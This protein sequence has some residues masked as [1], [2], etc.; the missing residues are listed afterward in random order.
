MRLARTQLG[1]SLVV[2][3][4][5]VV[6]SVQAQAPDQ[7]T[8]SALEH[9]HP[10]FHVPSSNMK[11][12]TAAARFR[13]GVTGI[14]SLVNFSGSYS[15]FGY[16]TV[17]N[18]Q[19]KWFYNMVGKSPDQGG[20]TVI[21]APIVPVSVLLLDANGAP[22]YSGGHLLYSDAT[23][24]VQKLVQSPIFENFQYSSSNTPTQ[25]SDAVQRAEFWRVI[26]RDSKD[27]DP[28]N[29]WHTLLKP[30]VK[31]PRLMLL[32]FG[33]YQFALN[34]DG[35]CCSFLLVDERTFTRNLF[36]ATYPVDGTTAVGAAELA[37]DV[38]TADMS[39]FLFPN[40]Y[41]YLN[42][43]VSDCC[44]LGFHSYDVEPG[45]PEN[46][47]L[48]RRY[49]LNYSSWISPG[50]FGGGFEDITAASH[51]IAEIY[52]DPFV[53]SD[54][55]LNVTPWWRAPDGTTCMNI[56]ET[57]DV[58]EGLP[59][60]TYPINLNGFTYHPQNEAL[61][62]WFEFRAPSNAIDQAYSYPDTSVLT[63]L[64]DVYK[65]GCK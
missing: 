7:V 28:G 33:S 24:Y 62:Q 44:V 20:T 52:N 43:N 51:E 21:N 16:D 57:G 54:G 49:V 38:T 37:G 3:L 17:G 8:A 15:T 27:G 47:N 45:V 60:A 61:L 19:S 23:Q 9:A 1:L 48:E 40:T 63:A 39:T 26:R 65:P 30:M 35:S 10:M 6:W 29:D 11:N 13:M 22:R 59:N 5:S 31:T 42:G 64:S 4:F 58:I 32:P 53:A 46:R 18:P 56:L 50:L 25:F 12:V 34:K 2:C 41:L 55:I 36:P 14:D